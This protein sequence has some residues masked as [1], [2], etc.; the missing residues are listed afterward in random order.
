[1]SAFNGVEIFKNSEWAKY[2][3]LTSRVEQASFATDVD[4]VIGSGGIGLIQADTG[5]GKTL[6]YLAP[7]LTH[8]GNGGRVIIATWSI[9]LIRQIKERDLELALKAYFKSTEM[10]IP[11]ATLYGK[12]N[13]I[14]PGRVE[15]VIDQSD[16]TDDQLHYLNVMH[17][18]SMEP[19]TTGLLQD[20]I[21]LHGPLPEKLNQD[22][23]TLTQYHDDQPKY[24]LQREQASTASIILTS[25]A[26]LVQQCLYPSESGAIPESVLARKVKDLLIVDEADALVAVF[27]SLSQRR[28]NLVHMLSAARQAKL[29]EAVIITLES[30]INR[31]RYLV[32]DHQGNPYFV[33]SSNVISEVSDMAKDIDKSLR[34][35][36]RDDAKNVRSE[37]IDKVAQFTEFSLVATTGGIG[38]SR[39]REEPA[40]IRISPSLGRAFGRRLDRYHSVLLVSATLSLH[41]NLI[42]GT[43]WLIRS[44]GLPTDRISLIAAHAPRKFGA[45]SLVLAGP[46]FPAPFLRDDTEEDIQ[47]NQQWLA[48][49]VDHIR[50]LSGNVLVLTGSYRETKLLARLLRAVAGSLVRE[51]VIGERFVDVLRDFQ[52][53]GGV[54]LTPSGGIGTSIIGAD[55]RTFVNHLVITRV[56]FVPKDSQLDEAWITHQQNVHGNTHVYWKNILF[57]NRFASTVQTLKQK[58]GR[59]IRTCDDVVSVHILDKRFPTAGISGK[60]SFIGLLQAIPVRFRDDWSRAKILASSAVEEDCVW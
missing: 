35:M 3:G 53:A 6:G 57:T 43:K 45:M 5:I 39:V 7:A 54:L 55:G 16:L 44:L 38:V 24:D 52:S 30:C 34:R 15:Y 20:F 19:S 60:S 49:C 29:S 59:A 51:H 10:S 12:G 21:D 25:H 9:Q 2:L 56:P 36:K 4:K 58:I 14:S 50:K 47:L 33:T 46:N 8:V 27:Q 11:V 22:Q 13:F 48:E 17:R 28:V 18:W 32:K 23:L 40:W 1:M 31:T 41:D 42:Q 37:L 26:M